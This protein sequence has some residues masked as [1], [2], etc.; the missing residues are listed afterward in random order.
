MITIIFSYNSIPKFLD[1]V[2]NIIYASLCYWWLLFPPESSPLLSL[3]NR[4]S[5]SAT[6]GTDVFEIMCRIV[7]APEF[8]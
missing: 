3:C 2:N 8:Q 4:F 7:I 6:D 5:V 1:K